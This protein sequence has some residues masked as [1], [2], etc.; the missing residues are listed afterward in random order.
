[1]VEV[2]LE[3][4]SELPRE[5]EGQAVLASSGVPRKVKLRAAKDSLKLS[6]AYRADVLLAD[7]VRLSLRGTTVDMQRV[8]EAAQRFVRL[9]RERRPDGASLTVAS[10][11][12]GKIDVAEAGT[13][14]PPASAPGKSAPPMSTR[15]TP[16]ALPAQQ[17]GSDPPAPA[18][19][20][21]KLAAL[22]RRISQLEAALPQL[23][24]AQADAGGDGPRV[25]ELEEKLGDAEARHQA[26]EQRVE[27]L[28]D[29]LRAA[30]ADAVTREGGVEQRLEAAERTLRQAPAARPVS[31]DPELTPLMPQGGRRQTRR[32]TAVDAFADGLRAEL[33]TRISTALKALAP[34]LEKANRAA[35][36]GAEGA[37]SHLVP[38]ALS[39]ELRMVAAQVAARQQALRRIDEE[40]DFYEAA[41]LPVAA[42]LVERLEKPHAAADPVELVRKAVVSAGAGKRMDTA[43]LSSWLSHAA[44]LCG[45]ELLH[46]L[47][48]EAAQAELHDPAPG[49]ELRGV[50]VRTVL[51]GVRRSEGQLLRRPLVESSERA[52]PAAPPSPEP[53]AAAESPA[54]AELA[55][56]ASS[57]A[58]LPAEPIV[59]L[60]AADEI[61]DGDLEEAEVIGTG[62]ISAPVIVEPHAPPDPAGSPA[63]APSVAAPAAPPSEAPPAPS[64]APRGA[65]DLWADVSSD[66]AWESISLSEAAHAPAPANPWEPAHAAD[67]PAAVEKPT[68]PT[69]S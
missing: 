30:R 1:M 5:F 7:I 6:T 49:S 22:E 10:N 36:L 28:Q 25:R 21:D 47:P 48:G 54:P 61:G 67:A 13:G 63:E 62:P 31:L 2:P 42:L 18:G 33:R 58:A 55:I 15:P 4:E 14:A 46:A 66:A 35:T 17:Q 23:F 9:V 40:S 24:E 39:D 50:V 32:T 53:P 43:G 64:A 8:Q 45:D 20:A 68:E 3:L 37:A 38:T 51:P 29:E 69:K 52:A 12:R 60:H 56:P 26:L 27:S 11:G 65:G 59:E 34:V 16:G 44:A 41:D 19:H 57:P